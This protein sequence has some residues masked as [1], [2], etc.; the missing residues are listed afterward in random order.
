VKVSGFKP[1]FVEYIPDRLDEGVLYLSMEFATAS[2]ACACGCGREVVTPLSPVGWQMR[3][4]G[5]N[6]SLE[7]SIGNWSYPCRSHY[8]IKGGHVRWDSEM[9]QWAIDEGRE[10]DRQA[11]R[12]YYAERSNPAAPAA[13]VEQ[14]PQLHD[15][16]QEADVPVSRTWWERLISVFR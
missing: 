6:V 10:R 16:T 3:Y 11:T 2:H 9:P 5:E 13:Q 4:D 15:V 14:A 7:P 1:M 8:W 12:R